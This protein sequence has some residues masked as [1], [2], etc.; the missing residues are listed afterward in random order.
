MGSGC[1]R[2]LL[3][4]D[5]PLAAWQAGTARLPLQM[6]FDET[7]SA[8]DSQCQDHSHGQHQPAHGGGEGEPQPCWQAGRQGKDSLCFCLTFPVAFQL[9]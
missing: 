4:A 9:E 3:H 8:T 5:T 7:S 6:G 2:E 1:P